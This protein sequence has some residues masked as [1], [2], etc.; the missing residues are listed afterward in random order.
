MQHLFFHNKAFFHIIAFHFNTLNKNSYIT[1][2]KNIFIICFF[3]QFQLNFPSMSF[4]S[5]FRMLI[6]QQSSTTSVQPAESI[7]TKME[8]FF[9]RELRNT[10]IIAVDHGYG[11]IKT[12][13]TV[14]P[15]GIKAYETEPI[16]TGNILEYNDIF[17]RIG[18]GH[19]EFI[20]DKA[21]DEEYYLLTLMAIARELNVFS[22][23]EAE[24]HLAAGLPLTWIRNQ[25]EEF[26]SY[27]LQNP[28]VH[29]RFNSKEYHL[30]F[31]GCSLYPQGYPAIVNRLGDF[32]GTNLLADIGNGTMNI[33]YI[34]NKKAQES[35]CWTEKLGVNQCMIAAKNAVLDKF[36]VKIE[37]STVEQILRFGTADISAP[38]LD[39]ISSIARQYVAELFST[40]RKYEYNPDLMRLYVVGGG[41]CLIRNFGTYDKS[42]VTIIDDICAT[43]KGYESLAYMSLK[44]RG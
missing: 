15:T 10:K 16:F 29:Y 33:L 11:N 6:S 34:N 36:G 14:T 5:N 4:P 19:K 41:G 35:R 24:V 20:P 18:E 12:A 21:I 8:V 9:M 25:R 43:A 39:C 13:N 3:S 42:R 23:Q 31:V 32:K 30:R 40:L 44:R 38:Y 27:L 37:E 7:N 26:R 2:L 1:K 17:Y 22:I 28:E